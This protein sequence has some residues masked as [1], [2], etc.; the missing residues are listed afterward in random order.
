MAVALL[1][2]LRIQTYHDVL[3]RDMLPPRSTNNR[4][5]FQI[6]R[7]FDHFDMKIRGAFDLEQSTRDVHL[8]KLLNGKLIRCSSRGFLGGV[9]KKSV[10]F[11]LTPR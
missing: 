1:F 8:A 3:N 7:V 11:Y 5:A 10:H 6:E 4:Q 9:A 2:F